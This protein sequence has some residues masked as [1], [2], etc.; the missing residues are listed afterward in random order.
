MMNFPLKGE[1][2]VKKSPERQLNAQKTMS[3]TMF[4]STKVPIT[5]VNHHPDERF[6]V[7]QYHQIHHLGGFDKSQTSD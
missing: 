2:E 4:F 3:R 5:V 7:S 6:T 1:V